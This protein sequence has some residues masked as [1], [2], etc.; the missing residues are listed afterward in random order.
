MP[1]VAV[2][3][4]IGRVVLAA[5][6]ADGVGRGMMERMDAM[7][8]YRD[9]AAWARLPL[10]E[11]ERGCDVQAFHATGPGGQGVNTADS[12]VRMRHR[13]SGIT[14]TSRTSRSQYRNRRECLEKLRAEL[15]RRAVRPKR[16][17]KTKPSRAARERRMADKRRR[18]QIKANRSRP[19]RDD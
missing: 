19:G 1:T 7:P 18:S 13:A 6:R 17:K 12:A 9:F 14:V 2:H 11:L 10:E 15:E 5:P 8:T 3:Y 16:R 4:V